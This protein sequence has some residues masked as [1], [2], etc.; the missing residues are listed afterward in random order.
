LLGTLHRQLEAIRSS[1]YTVQYQKLQVSVRRAERRLALRSAYADW[2]RA[3]QERLLCGPV[4][5]AVSQALQ[6]LQRRERDGLMLAS[7]AD[8]ARNEWQQV[9]APCVDQS[10]A[11]QDTRTTLEVIVQHKLPAGATAVSDPLAEHPQPLTAWR[12]ALEQQPS[13]AARRTLVTEAE[14]NL[15]EP[16]YESIE[17]DFSVGYNAEDRSGVTTLGHGL[18]ASVNFTMPFGAA[19][20]SSAHHQAN[21]ARYVSATKQLSAERRDLLVELGKSLRTQRE[22]SQALQSRDEE[23]AAAELL[24]RDQRDRGGLDGEGTYLQLQAAQR[25]VYQAGFARIAAWHQLWLQNAA[26]RLLV[27]NDPQADTLLG[28]EHVSWQGQVPQ[29]A[30]IAA[31]AAGA[32]VAATRSRRVAGPSWYQGVYIWNSDALL[33]PARRPAELL[34]LGSAGMRQIYVG[35]DSAQLMRLAQTKQ[36]L[37]ALIKD[38]GKRNL[39]VGLLLGDPAWMS[40]SGRSE[41]ISLIG[42]L[43]DLQFSSLNLDL[44]V[45]QRGFPVPDEHLRDWID[46]VAAAVKASPWPVELSSHYRWFATPKVGHTCV[47]CSLSRLGVASISLMIY[48]RNPKRSTE[49]AAQIAKRWPKLSFRLAQSVEPQL[50]PQESWAGASSSQIDG[51]ED[52]WRAKLEPLG[53][54]GIDWQDWRSYPRFLQGG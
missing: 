36:S 20:H 34:A 39:R 50:T 25:Q 3:Q 23:L 6:Q 45:E 31:V 54:T 14:K 2:W 26:L 52:S 37:A 47:P 27:D 51:Q 29:S 7:D 10:A 4:Q 8:L 40:P 16:W 1:E 42:S 30:T 48:V 43:K 22:A 11:E 19:S 13:M 15:D 12:A 38:A 18:V 35:V 5:A 17:S 33:D 9:Q 41:L 46:T 21:V 53:I 24:L 49:L 28:S 44:E 32:T